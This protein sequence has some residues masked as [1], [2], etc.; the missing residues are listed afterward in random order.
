MLTEGN[1]AIFGV[2]LTKNDAQTNNGLFSPEPC[3]GHD[4][5]NFLGGMHALRTRCWVASFCSIRWPCWVWGRVLCIP[6]LLFRGPDV[7][8]SYA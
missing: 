5:N 4:T 1:N 7:G 2:N 3:V 6:Y 8:R